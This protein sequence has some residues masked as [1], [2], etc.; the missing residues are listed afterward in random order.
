MYLNNPNN[1]QCFLMIENNLPEAF[2]FKYNN[3]NITS[4]PDPFF[5]IVW[6]HMDGNLKCLTINN[7]DHFFQET[8]KEIT[9]DNF[10]K[11]CFAYHWHNRWGEPELKNSPAGRLNQHLDKIIEE[12]YNIK[13]YQIFQS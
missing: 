11:G 5:D 2:S 6:P 10:F 4:L 8:D 13:P 12:K 3:L 7:F 9:L 1:S